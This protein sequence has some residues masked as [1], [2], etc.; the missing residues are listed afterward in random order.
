MPVTIKK[1][2]QT[3]TVV[4]DAPFDGAVPIEAKPYSEEQF[5]EDLKMLAKAT[6]KKTS[7]AAEAQVF[8][9]KIKEFDLVNK[10]VEERVR[11]RMLEL[12]SPNPKDK[13]EIVIANTRVELGADS[14]TRE[15][16]DK[17]KLK[18][19]LGDEAFE[20]LWSVNLGDIDKYTTPQQQLQF[21]K[22]GWKGNR[23][24]VVS[25]VGGG[26]VAVGKKKG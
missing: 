3:K 22:Y 4:E 8:L 15:I 11:A 16:E 12:F 13:V 6:A 17:A 5:H 19:A 7:L 14:Q 23:K 9:D 1:P 18:A 26:T 21:L 24:L 20:A 2:L 25:N 10:P